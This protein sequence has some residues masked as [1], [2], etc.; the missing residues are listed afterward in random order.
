MS[1]KQTTNLSWQEYRRPDVGDPA[2]VSARCSKPEPH[3][4]RV[5]LDVKDIGPLIDSGRLSRKRELVIC[6]RLLLW[7]FDS[8]FDK[9]WFGSLLCHRLLRP[10]FASSSNRASHDGRTLQ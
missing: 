8:L 7:V 9:R 3:A 5:G 2:R 1:K 6:L 4:K 10:R